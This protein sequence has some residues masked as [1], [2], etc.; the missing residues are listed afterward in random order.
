MISAILGLKRRSF[1]FLNSFKSENNT[2]LNHFVIIGLQLIL[3][4]ELCSYTKLLE[5]K[6]TYWF[7]FV[8]R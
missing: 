3:R 5:L 8:Q 2:F 1:C 6:N 4:K 7:V